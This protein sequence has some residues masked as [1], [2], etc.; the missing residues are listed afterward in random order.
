MSCQGLIDISYQL[1]AFIS[2]LPYYPIPPIT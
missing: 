1:L 2:K